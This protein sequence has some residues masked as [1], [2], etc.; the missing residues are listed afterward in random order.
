MITNLLSFF[1]IANCRLG[2]GV[3]EIKRIVIVKVTL[4]NKNTP[5][6][7]KLSLAQCWINVARN[8]GNAI[9]SQTERSFWSRNYRSSL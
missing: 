8:A 5:K 1:V 9:C 3:V 7:F 2:L 4:P 6:T